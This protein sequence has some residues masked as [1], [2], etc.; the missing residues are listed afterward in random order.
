MD[1]FT[2][3]YLFYQEARQPQAAGPI[4]TGPCPVRVSEALSTVV[5]AL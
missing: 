1:H 5:C 2:R 4:V 3:S